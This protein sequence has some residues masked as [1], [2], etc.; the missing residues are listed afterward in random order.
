MRWLSV[1]TALIALVGLAPSA[2]ADVGFEELRP[3]L[4]EVVLVTAINE[5]GQT[6]GSEWAP[7]WYRGSAM[8]WEGTV[9]GSM[10]SGN[11]LGIDER[12]AAVIVYGNKQGGAEFTYIDVWAD[13]VR[14]RRTPPPSNG[15]GPMTVRDL[16]GGALPIGYDNPK[17]PTASYHPDQA[18]VWRDGT[19]SDITFGEKGTV[20]HRAV[21][22]IGTTAGALD[23]K[24][25]V[26]YAFRCAAVGC[27]RLPAAGAGGYYD[28]KA[29]N[30][31]DV[32]VGDWRATSQVT[33]VVVW[34]GDR[35]VVLPGEGAGAADNV[36]AL[37]ENGDV[38]G[39]RTENGVRRA[40]LWRGGRLVD[41]GASGASEAVAVND[42][43]DVVGWHTVEGAPHPF[44]WRAGTLSGL[45]TPENVPAKPKALNNAGIAV[46]S[47]LVAR[48][49]RSFRW[50]IP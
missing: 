36:R 32:V 8:R 41:L 24:G 49:G 12:G 13:G 4:G 19:Y 17:D 35:A 6:V 25:G 11:A 44:H 9:P 47:T 34:T 27:T 7:G 14:T 5:A 23:P 39:W 2:G 16:G 28:V 50:T 40:T 20:R 45:P 31:A 46:G 29:I 48:S 21:N 26:P 15:Y 22:G 18:A 37:N 33:H 3:A 30:D 38:V 43:G 42:R 1:S 10:G